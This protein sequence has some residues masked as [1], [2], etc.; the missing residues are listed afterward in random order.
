VPPEL[1]ALAA[2]VIVQF[3]ALTAYSVVG[4]RQLGHRVTLGPRDK[5]PP[6]SP[7]LGRLQRCAANGFEGLA[8]FTPAVLVVVLSG[9]SSPLT[10]AAAWTYV[11]ARA[12]YIPAYA[13]GLVPWRSLVWGIGAGAI[14]LMLFAALT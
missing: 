4:N 10:A 12:L 6:L 11:A 8:L 13:L 1:A 3:A 9:Q 7:L 2:A 5:L 14:C